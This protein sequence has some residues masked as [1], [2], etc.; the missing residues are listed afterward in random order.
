MPYGPGG[1]V[2]SRRQL[3]A[4]APRNSPSLPHVLCWA[5]GP[6]RLT[7]SKLLPTY[8]N[9]LVPTRTSTPSLCPPFYSHQYNPYPTLH[10]THTPS[11]LRPMPLP[12]LRQR[13]AP[14]GGGGLRLL[15]ACV[16]HDPLELLGR[17]RA[18]IEEARAPALG[19]P[20]LPAREARQVV[21]WRHVH[22]VAM[23]TMQRVS[24]AITC[25]RPHTRGSL[26]GF[27]VRQTHTA[28]TRARTVLR[29]WQSVHLWLGPPWSRPGPCLCTC[30]RRRA[31]CSL[32]A[33]STSRRVP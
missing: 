4:L 32:L 10:H 5:L 14:L 16:L 1:E 6:K 13:Q 31:S 27:Q 18:A 17:D 25:I 12:P 28:H 33:T 19:K 29:S 26:E 9:I 2:M 22:L 24:G 7:Q 15:R 21:A 20:R 30:M 11:P 3:L 23:T 8:S